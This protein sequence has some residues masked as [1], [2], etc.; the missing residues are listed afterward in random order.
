MQH[1]HITLQYSTQKQQSPTALMLDTW[2]QEV[3]T[4]VVPSAMMV[5]AASRIAVVMMLVAHQYI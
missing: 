3:S 4:Q 2:S 1:A 5:N